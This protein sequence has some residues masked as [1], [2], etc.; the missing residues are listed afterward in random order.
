[1][2]ACCICGE[3]ADLAVSGRL[4]P[5]ACN[6][7]A[8][9]GEIFHVWR[10]ERCRCIHAYEDVDLAAYYETYPFA[11]AT[12]A[13]PM[14]IV[15]R[16]QL[17]R[18]KREGLTRADRLLDYGCGNGVFVAYL[19][20]QGY[21]NAVGYDPYGPA[22]GLG[23]PAVLERG[24]FDFIVLQDVVE[25]VDDPAGL[26]AKLDH[27]LKAGGHVLVG[28]PNADRIDLRQPDRF[29]NEVH[30]PYHRHIV[31]R[32]TLNALGRPLGWT[33]VRFY[34]RPY[35]DL[36]WWGLNTRAIHTYQKL[37]DGTLD[38]VLEP[39]RLGVALRSP[40]FL[41]HACFGYLLS[42]RSDMAVLFR[43]G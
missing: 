33:P 7:R 14:P 35:H 13:W 40:R 20:R 39:V 30:V 31:T 25:H 12:L 8:H 15:Y 4:A 42:T 34:D 41:F 36:P 16:A 10:C 22:V 26:L 43:K 2:T 28:T 17:A 38:A 5:F 3:P 9:R 32:E 23:N 18:L 21:R 29:C 1:M 6:V 27:C 37:I 19:R 24:P 11:S